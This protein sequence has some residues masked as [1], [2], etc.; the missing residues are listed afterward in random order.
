[1]K[2]A[3]NVNHYEH[4]CYSINDTPPS[5]GWRNW[6]TQ[7]TQNPPGFGPWGF[8]SPSRHQQDKGLMNDLCFCRCTIFGLIVTFVVTS[9]KSG[10]KIFDLVTVW[11]G[12]NKIVTL[13]SGDAGRDPLQQ[14]CL[15][16]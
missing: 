1:M 11:P 16:H 6:Q 2:S 15:V 9:L 5:P 4:L 3:R 8:D 10:A 13:F 7:R 12:E 14:E